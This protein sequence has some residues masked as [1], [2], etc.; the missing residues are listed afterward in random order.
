[1]RHAAILIAFAATALRGQTLLVL[2]TADEPDRLRFNERFIARNG[3]ASIVGER[4]VKRE[5]EPM[6]PERERLLWR[7]DE[8]GRMVY[9]N[10]S[11]GQPGSGRD[12]ASATYEYDGHGRLARRLRNDLAGHFAQELEYDAQGR[13]TRETHQRIENL[14]AN[15]YALVPGAVTEISDERYRYEQPGDTLLRKTFLNHLGLPYRQQTFVSD[16]NGY[17]IAIDDHYL[18]SNRRGR[19]TFTYDEY[20]RLSTRTEQ[21]DL[22]QPRLLRHEW[23]YDAMGN[24]TEGEVWDEQRQIHRDEYLYEE[25]TLLLKARLRKDLATG[26]IHVLKL[27]AQRR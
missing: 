19:I 23:R 24:V 22:G 15:R 2:P 8:Q 13:V 3:I 1:M 10:H 7:F 25:G 11:Y 14:S 16:R 4:L 17:L 27:S 5:R 6:R 18:V 20:G 26:A 12:T 21:P 9:S